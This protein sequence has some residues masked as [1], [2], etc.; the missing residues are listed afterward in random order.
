MRRV[1]FGMNVSLDGFVADASGD[2]G[3]SVPGD[4]LFE[5]WLQQEHASTLSLYG[6]KL[7]ED[8]SGYWPARA[9]DRDVTPAQAEFAR[10]F[11]ST[12]KMVF[13]STLTS[14]GWGARLV[15]GDAV[16]EIARLRAED[17][18]PMKLGGAT[19]GAA[20]VKAGLVD[21]LVVVTHPVLLGSGL[22]FLPALDSPMA[23][24]LLETRTFP[25]GVVLSRYATRREGS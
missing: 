2:L 14:V 17:G 13:S 25:G 5:W 4:E 10:T 9:Q 7:W 18:G 19:L 21:E 22:P 23:L 16:A 11:V 3:W 12:P 8:M 24:T 20:V 15:S 6:R 1:V